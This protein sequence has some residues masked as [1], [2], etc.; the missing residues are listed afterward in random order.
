MP[1]AAAERS[2]AVARSTT[3]APRP[4][5]SVRTS[6]RP[7][8]A[9]AARQV[10]VTD[11]LELERGAGQVGALLDLQRQLAR[12]GVVDRRCRPS[13]RRR[14]A[15]RACA[16]DSAVAAWSALSS[17]ARTATGSGTLP[18][19]HPAQ[20]GEGQHRRQVAHG[21]APALVLLTGLH[22]DVVGQGRARRAVADGDQ[23]RRE[24]RPRPRLA[25]PRWWPRSRPRARRRSPGRRRGGRPISSKACT[26][27]TRG[28]ATPAARRASSSRAAPTMA[29]CSLVP[30][31]V[32]MIGPP[33]SAVARM[34]S[35]QCPDGRV[36]G[37][38][39]DQAL[40]QG[41]LGGDH[42]GHGVR[43]AARAPPAWSRRPMDR[44]RRGAARRHRRTWRR[45]YLAGIL[46]RMSDRPGLP[47]PREAPKAGFEA[48]QGRRPDAPEPAR[49]RARRRRA[50][51]RPGAVVLRQR[52]HGRA[53]PARQPRGVCPSPAAAA[54]HDRHLGDRHHGRGA[55][56]PLVHAAVHLP[57][58][59][60]PP[61]AS[62]TASWPRPAPRRRATSPSPSRPPPAP[63]W[64]RSRRSAARAG[65]RS[66]CWRIPARGARWSSA[67]WPRATRRS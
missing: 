67:W 20:D 66:T 18:A 28:S 42:L 40:G 46:G 64:P 45:C 57:H 30:Q 54:G 3:T 23:R 9:S 26:D 21:V 12:R 22:Q 32:R 6:T 58:R 8:S 63:T 50:A 62:A 55:G 31:P 5:P 7:V 56:P 53:D 14:H 11:R 36:I 52:R 24:R 41:R 60:P 65:S 10:A 51:V 48:P 17:S 49:L 2:T 19:E 39:P 44:G 37:Q 33:A 59:P 15:A 61:G 1:S 13:S 16:I 29:A 27:A 47:V 35:R 25:A 34:S 4:S 43:R 38:A